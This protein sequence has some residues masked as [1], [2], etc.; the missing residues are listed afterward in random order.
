MENEGV[1][2]VEAGPLYGSS[3]MPS[4]VGER[5]RRLVVVRFWLFIS[6]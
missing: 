3:E 1:E 2:V 6:L 4:G 5:N